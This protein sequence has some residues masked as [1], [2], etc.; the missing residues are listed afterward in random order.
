MSIFLNDDG[1]VQTGTLLS[2][3]QAAQRERL[4]AY[5]HKEACDG[6]YHPSYDQKRCIAL[7]NDFITGA[8]YRAANAEVAP[9]VELNKE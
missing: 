1:L 8:I 3:E 6:K 2:D 7:A 9:E 5:F 4:I